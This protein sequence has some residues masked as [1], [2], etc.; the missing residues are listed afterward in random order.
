MRRISKNQSIV[1]FFLLIYYHS[2]SFQLL[3]GF[4]VKIAT[5][6]SNFEIGCKVESPQKLPSDVYQ[7]GEV[8]FVMAAGDWP[9]YFCPSIKQGFLVT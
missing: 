7:G 9:H 8:T 4:V 1:V 5:Q 2:N 6:Y 3:V